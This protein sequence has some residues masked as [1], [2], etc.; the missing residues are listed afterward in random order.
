MI[1]GFVGSPRILRPLV[2]PD[3]R[4]QPRTSTFPSPRAAGNVRGG[5]SLYVHWT[6]SGRPPATGID[7]TIPSGASVPGHASI[8]ARI[9]ESPASAPP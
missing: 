5:S 9:G 4:L 1:D 3:I 2:R 8:Y 6:P 7:A